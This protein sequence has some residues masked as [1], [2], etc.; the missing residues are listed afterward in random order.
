MNKIFGKIEG[1]SIYREEGSRYV[2]SYGMELASD[3]VNA[4]WYEVY[5][6]K[7]KNSKPNFDKIKEVITND[8]NAR[9][10]EKIL[11][12]F[13]WNDIN[14]WLSAENQ[15]NFSEAQRMTEKYGDK[16]LPLRFKLGEDEEGNPVYYTFDTVDELDSFYIQAFSYVNKCLNE[17]WVIKDNF[18][19]KPYEELF[20]NVSEK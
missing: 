8:I 16:A 18:D 1:F 11:N 5:L 19:W 2:L 17:G 10:D 6:N 3:G 14:V 15:R 9:T 13:V 7:N 4:T 20:S 12:G